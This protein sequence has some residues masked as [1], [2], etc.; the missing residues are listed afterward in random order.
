M[1]FHVMWSKFENSKNSFFVTSHLR[2][3]L[4]VCNMQQNRSLEKQQHI[5]N[6]LNDLS[7]YA[8]SL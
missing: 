8:G 3:L 1:F 5:S 7:I 6:C 2:T 4:P